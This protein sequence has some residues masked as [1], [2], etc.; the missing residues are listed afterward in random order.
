MTQN[1][2]EY[3]Y[4]ILIIL[5]KIIYSF[6][7][8]FSILYKMVGTR[9]NGFVGEGEGSGHAITVLSKGP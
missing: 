2:F 7:H 8:F 9:P 4:Q 3:R 5:S 1:G 6:E